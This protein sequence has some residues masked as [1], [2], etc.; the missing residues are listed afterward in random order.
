MYG[1]G[2]YDHNIECSYPC[3]SDFEVIPERHVPFTSNTYG[4]ET[5]IENNPEIPVA[6]HLAC[7][8]IG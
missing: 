8:L 4:E 1:Y 2:A 3:H 5:G 6:K 7:D